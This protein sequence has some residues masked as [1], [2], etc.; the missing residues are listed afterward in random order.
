MHSKAATLKTLR[1][2]ATSFEDGIGTSPTRSEPHS[3][4]NVSG[5]VGILHSRCIAKFLECNLTRNSNSKTDRR[6]RK[7][8]E[9]ERLFSKSS[10]TSVAVSPQS[11]SGLFMQLNNNHCK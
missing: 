6:N 7:F 3:L 2:M 8:K 5:S 4:L 9:A 11:F 1:C 10:V